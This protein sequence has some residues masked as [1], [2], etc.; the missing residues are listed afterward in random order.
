MKQPKCPKCGKLM[1]RGPKAASGKV[2]WTCMTYTEGDRQYCYSTTNPEAN[3]VRNQKGDTVGTPKQQV[4][5]R[6]LEPVKRYIITAAQNATPVH[7]EFFRC[8]LTACHHLDAELLVIPIRYKNATSQ[9]TESQRNADWWLDKPVLPYELANTK[10]T[11]VEYNARVYPRRKYLWN[12]RRVLNDN[13]VLLADIKTQPTASSPLTAFDGIT[14]SRSAIVGHTKLHLKTVATP[15][16]RMPKIL[17]TTGACTVVNYTDSKAGKLGEFHH[18]LGA[19]VVEIQGKKFHMRQLNGDKTTGEFTDLTWHYSRNSVSAA[20]APL[21]LIMGD[22]H[23]DFIDPTV[24]KATFGKGG[25]VDTLKPQYLLW[26]DLLDGYSVNPHHE[27]LMNEMAKWKAQRQSI[28]DEINRAVGF[29]AKRTPA[30]TVSVVVS[31]N[32]DAFLRRWMTKTM[33]YGI[34]DPVNAK[35]F[36]DTGSMMADSA[37]LGTGGTVTEDPFIYWAEKLYPTMVSKTA[38]ALRCLHGDESFVL[39]GVELGMH[40]DR[41]PNG[42]KGS[43]RNLRRIGVRS[44]IGH[45]HSPGIDEGCY[46]VGTSTRLR[47]EYTGGPSSWL[48]THCILY[49]TGKRALINIIDG[50][51][52]LE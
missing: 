20:P 8:L 30:D 17:T 51:W 21:A 12:V 43:I 52:R 41:G 16:N 48:N 27:S 24:E 31:S 36:F 4:F 47:L 28:R 10:E 32:H 50:D 40:G 35:F 15:Q 34:H 37:H 6:V 19:L 1:T 44:V 23:V 7:D 42:S 38:G 3:V 45:S 18:T 39:E 11:E 49:A 14:G 13:L 46:Q 26:H 25:I 9:W 29:V 5:K 22:T 33:R 2:R